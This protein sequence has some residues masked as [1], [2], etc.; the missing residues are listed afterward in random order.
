MLTYI[1]HKKGI[2]NC[3]SSYGSE[4][5]SIMERY[6]KGEIDLWFL[7]DIYDWEFDAAVPEAFPDSTFC[8]DMRQLYYQQGLIYLKNFA[9]YDDINILEVES[10]F[11]YDIDDW[12]FN[13]V[14]DLVYEDKDGKLVIQDYKSKSLFKSKK[15]LASYARQ[16][17]LYSLYITQKYGRPPDLM[18]FVL[19]RKNKEVVIPYKKADLLEA[20]T[21]AKN[22]VNDIRCCFDYAPSCEDF[23]CHNLCNH[24]EYCE[25]RDN[26]GGDLHNY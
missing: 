5:H 11:D 26:K 17:Y 15:E 3:F 7:A 10:K 21:W 4:V 24:R 20:V 22:T 12:V 9:G 25:M 16:L 14:I 13:G 1:E 8:K 6:A 18:K 23:Y 2:G 19:F